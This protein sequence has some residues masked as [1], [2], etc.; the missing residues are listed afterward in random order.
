[1]RRLFL[2]FFFTTIFSINLIGQTIRI[3][4][5]RVEF[6]EDSNPLTTGNGTFAIDSIT[7]ELFAVDPAPHNKTYFTDQLIAADNYFNNVSGGSVRIIGDVFPQEQDSSYKLSREMKYYN[8]N[9]SLKDTDKGIANLFIDAVQVADSD[10]ALYYSDYDLVVIFHAGVGRDIDLGFDETPQDIPSL[11]VTS[12]FVSQNLDTVFNGI[13]VDNGSSIVDRAII[14]PETENQQGF[15]I[16]LTGILVSNIGSYL[17]LY[18]LFSNREQ[19]SG[20]GR[21]GLMDA[22]L[23]NINGL[24]PAPPSALVEG[25]W[26]GKRL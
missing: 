4:A 5:I 12:Q 10:P 19:R 7:T 22:G 9:T 21:F 17:G 26:V 24:I 1:M 18:D 23:L 6:I 14:L 16:A 13:L 3:A 8:P 15:Q 20:I 25:Y 11:F 2:I